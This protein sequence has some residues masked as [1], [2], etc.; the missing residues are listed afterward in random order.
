MSAP[1]RGRMASQQ[2]PSKNGKTVSVVAMSSNGTPL[3]TPLMSYYLNMPRDSPCVISVNN[4]GNAPRFYSDP[5]S[6]PKRDIECWNQA[7]I[8]E[9]ARTIRAQHPALAENVT[10][11]ASWEDLYRYYD[12]HDLWLQGAWNLWA[13]I[14]ELGYLNQKMECYHQKMQEIQNMGHRFPLQPYELSMIADFVEGWVSF[15]ENRLMLIDWDGSYDIL[16]LFSP[17]DWTEGGFDGLNQTQADFLRHEFTY[18]HGHWRERYENPVPFFPPDQWHHLGGK[19]AKKDSFKGPT[20]RFATPY[21]K[22]A[23]ALLGSRHPSA[24]N[25][26]IS[27]GP[28]A[29]YLMQPSVQLVGFSSSYSVPAGTF[30]HPMPF[31][32]PVP[33][34]QP[35]PVAHP[36][37]VSRSVPTGHPVVANGSTRV[38][39]SNIFKNDATTEKAMKFDNPTMSG[40][41][42]SFAQENKLNRAVTEASGPSRLPKRFPEE[43]MDKQG[44]QS[45][46]IG[47]EVSQRSYPSKNNDRKNTRKPVQ[48]RLTSFTNLK[49]SHCYNREKTPGQGQELAMGHFLAC[50]CN[51]CSVLSRTALVKQI[52]HPHGIP[53][54]EKTA[55][56]RDYFSRYGVVQQCDIKT[57]R[58]NT[59]YAFIRFSLEN[60]AVAAVASA[61]GIPLSP[62]SDRIRVEHPWFS[63]YWIPRYNKTPPKTLRVTPSSKRQS[64]SDQGSMNRAMAQQHVTRLSLGSPRSRTH[65]E[66]PYVSPEYIRGPPPGFPPPVFYPQAGWQPSPPRIQPQP[67]GMNGYHSGY[68]GPPHYQ[69][70]VPF[71]Q[72]MAQI[73]QKPQNHSSLPPVH[74]F[75]QGFQPQGSPQRHHRLPH[76]HHAPQPPSPPFHGPSRYAGHQS[77]PPFEGPPPFYNQ[78]SQFGNAQPPGNPEAQTRQPLKQ[79]APKSQ[80]LSHSSSSSGDGSIRIILPS[81]SSE[82]PAVFQTTGMEEFNKSCSVK[83]GGSPDEPSTPID[84]VSPR[85]GQHLAGTSEKPAQEEGTANGSGVA[86][87]SARFSIQDIRCSQDFSGTVKIR[88]NRRNQYQA[89]PAKWL[90]GGSR[91]VTPIEQDAQPGTEKETGSRN[92]TPVQQ[93]AQSGHKKGK[94]N[95]KK[96]GHRST[97]RPSTPVDIFSNQPGDSK[98]QAPTEQ[99]ESVKENAALQVPGSKGYRAD[100]GGSLKMSRNRKGPAIRSSHLAAQVQPPLKNGSPKEEP[101]AVPIASSEN[102]EKSITTNQARFRRFDSL[103]SIPDCPVLPRACDLFPN[104]PDLSTSPPKIVMTPAETTPVEETV[105]RPEAS[106]LTNGLNGIHRVSDSSLAGHSYCPSFYSAKS[107]LSSRANSPPGAKDELFLSPPETPAKQSIASHPSST[108]LSVHPS[109]KTEPVVP[110]NETATEPFKGDGSKNN[111]K[112]ATCEPAV[113]NSEV[114]Q[115]ET[116]NSDKPRFKKKTRKNNNP[117]V[118]ASTAAGPSSSRPQ[119]QQLTPCSTSESK[120]NS[121]PATPAENTNNN[122]NSKKKKSQAKNAAERKRSAAATDDAEVEGASSSTDAW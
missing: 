95:N 114:T 103:S 3:P 122:R 69:P 12:A 92:P 111:T 21:D 70:P 108:T 66:Q 56:L 10:A 86:I 17:V 105:S 65:M 20:K 51:R 58:K 110:V 81:M 26:S 42:T 41:A 112:P 38:P 109:P 57:T 87:W 63:K 85:Q 48:A 117:K 60:S 7:R 115:P 31:S 61:D 80:P 84:N 19:Y 29:P 90:S 34:S 37:P 118:K 32:Q 106:G 54:S 16:Q 68:L 30:S 76:W 52:G 88:P 98:A 13:V 97:S 8:E 27:S 15:K 120:P 79:E 94:K 18:W 101:L 49:Y 23:V 45:A 91:N 62:L 64:H 77:Q 71:H 2:F 22:P 121:R 72:Q 55:R 104:Y 39:H 93:G 73:P 44:Q 113:S 102:A 119:D 75:N 11:P 74:H 107:T 89:L 25:P 1:H 5:L 83:S 14:D 35:T 53:P 82:K 99:S 24:I 36:V 78:R 6:I 96:A 116:P 46:T 33:C 43:T 4:T 67:V 50:P 100:A 40:S 47:P 28:I 59:C 9:E